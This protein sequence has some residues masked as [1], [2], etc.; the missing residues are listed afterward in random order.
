MSNFLSSISKNHDNLATLLAAT[1][2]YKQG[3]SKVDFEH[4]FSEYTKLVY[5]AL[6]E[7]DSED[8]LSSNRSTILSAMS[9]VFE[10][11]LP[12]FDTAN[13]CWEIVQKWEE[14]NRK[15]AYSFQSSTITGAASKEP[16]EV[17]DGY[18]ALYKAQREEL[19]RLKRKQRSLELKVAFEERVFFV[20]SFEGWQTNNSADDDQE[21]INAFCRSAD[22][23]ALI[24]RINK[25]T[26]L[27]KFLNII[28]DFYFLGSKKKDR[29]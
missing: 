28:Y 16:W 29:N 3:A 7:M 24:D 13:R 9:R 2:W 21:L 17:M 18:K 26:L 25:D 1:K 10:V 19:R 15:R 14:R 22:K 5:N 11:D 20:D 23:L 27:S 4:F 8:D 12:H 6:T